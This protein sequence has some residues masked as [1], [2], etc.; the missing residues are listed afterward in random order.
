MNSEQYFL[1]L[2]EKV[3]KYQSTSQN[4]ELYQ[5]NILLLKF[6]KK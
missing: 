5:D 3:N 6:R 4:L 2:L 1:N